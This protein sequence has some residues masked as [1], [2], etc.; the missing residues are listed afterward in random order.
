MASK[1]NF[2]I[3]KK[4]PYIT[5]AVAVVVFVIVYFLVS[6][7]RGT[8]SSSA[9]GP[10]AAQIAAGAQAQA[11]QDALAGQANQNSFQLAYLQQQQ[12]LAAHQGD[13]SYNLGL[14]TLADQLTVAQQ[15]LATQLATT[16]ITSSA[17]TTQLQDQL[18]AQ[19]TINNQNN[20]AAMAQQATLAQEQEFS[21]AAQSQVESLISN[22]QTL[23]A[24]NQINATTAIAGINAA[25]TRYIAKTNAGSAQSSGFFGLAAAAIG[26]FL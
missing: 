2:A 3:I 18:N 5:A 9:S 7:S 14:N 4:H 6:G 23:V 1:F 8:V 15:Q 17:N 19:V 13:Q 10:S 25:T 21:I 26:A 24:N 11:G 16:Q 12:V 20:S 22:N